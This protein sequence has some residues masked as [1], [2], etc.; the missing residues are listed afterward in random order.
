[1]EPITSEQELQTLLDDGKITQEEYKELLAAMKDKPQASPVLPVG[2][3][4]LWGEYKSKRRI[5]DLPLVHI[6]YGPAID[7]AT[8]KLRVAKGIIAIGGIAVGVV[9]LGGA[10]FGLVAL[11][12]LAVGLLA[13]LGGAAIGTGI[14]I[15][16]FAVGTAALG[17]FAFGY[18]ALGGA[19]FGVYDFGGNTPFEQ[20][21]EWFKRFRR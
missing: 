20:W 7:P 15:G 10:A 14:S 19:A 12:G 3:V 17:G 21:P 6:V 4:I 16:G 8:G 1:M 11:G 18:Y 2:G 9:A 5:F 13:A